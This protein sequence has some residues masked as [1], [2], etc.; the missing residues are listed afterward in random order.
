MES[1]LDFSTTSV[2]PSSLACL[3]QSSRALWHGGVETATK[4]RLSREHYYDGKQT[5]QQAGTFARAGVGP[6]G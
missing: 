5:T 1:Y 6:G 3:K 4:T 2:Q